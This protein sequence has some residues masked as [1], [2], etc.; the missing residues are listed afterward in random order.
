MRQCELLD[1]CRSSLYYQPLPICAGDLALMR[2]IDALYLAHPFFGSRR[3]AHILRRQ[4]AKVGR[5]HVA[6]S[7]EIDR[8]MRLA[9]TFWRRNGY[10]KYH[11]NRTGACVERATGR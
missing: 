1:L 9:A 10:R 4:G 8:F 2:R 7:A 3:I 6:T 11:S 5:L